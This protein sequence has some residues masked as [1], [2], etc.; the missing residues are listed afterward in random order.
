MLVWIAHSRLYA[1]ARQGQRLTPW[2]GVLALSVAFNLLPAFLP[3]SEWFS[4]A[5]LAI[6]FGATILLIALWVGLYERRPFSTLGF[7]RAAALGKYGRGLI[8]GMLAFVGVIGLLALFGVVIVEP[9]PTTLVGAPAL[10]AVLLILPSW[11]IQGASE[12]IATRGWILPVIGARYRPL[13]GILSSTLFFTIMHALN[14]G[15]SLL[16]VANLA[17]YGLFAALYALR[18]GSLWGICAFHSVWN[19]A[20]GHVFGLSVSGMSLTTGTL[21]DLATRGPDVLTGGAFGPEGSLAAT[22]VF[23]LGIAILL[24]FPMAEGKRSTGST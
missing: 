13:L 12:E 10:P 19:W 3:L 24:L 21:L 20:Q 22:V 17:L 9:T 15:L 14:P 16:A 6:P 18:E 23:G 8:I 2:A 4:A 11:I 5:E 7:E 1:L